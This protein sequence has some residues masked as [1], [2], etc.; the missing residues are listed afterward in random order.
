MT[1]KVIALTGGI[2]SGKSEAASVLRG[3]GFKT[4]DCDK[5]SRTVA[6]DPEVIKQV[7]KL[8]GRKCVADGKLDRKAVREKVFAD[9]ALLD[10]Y[11][12]LF[13]EK[14]KTL[15]AEKLEKTEGTVFVEIPVISAFPFDWD[16]IW[17]IESDEQ[18]R[19]KRVRNR[20]N[21][22]EQNVKQI[23]SRQ[24]CKIDPTHTIINCG[25]RDYLKAQLEL[26][27]KQSKL[28]D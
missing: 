8:L 14:I 12:A 18:T 24:T 21:V 15:L 3:F 4:V 25:T 22:T 20:D 26:A 19:I 16:E 13:F 2:G 10:A 5:L 6:E 17:L 7:R 23:M 11:N 28:T 27:L 1:R 9:A